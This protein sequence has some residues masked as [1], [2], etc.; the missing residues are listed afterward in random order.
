MC[1]NWEEVQMTQSEYQTAIAEFIRRRGVTRCP[2]VC[3]APTQASVDVSDRSALRRRAEQ[4]EEL[5]QQRRSNNDAYLH[6]LS[7]GALGG[8]ARGL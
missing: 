2:T 3:L 7:R 8:S 4:L 5:R 6:E 1:C